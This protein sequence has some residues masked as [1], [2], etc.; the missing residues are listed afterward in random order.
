MAGDFNHNFD[1]P[2]KV[3]KWYNDMEKLQNTFDFKSIQGH[4]HSFKGNKKTNTKIDWIRGQNITI[5]KIK[6][7]DPGFINCDHKGIKARIEI[8]NKCCRKKL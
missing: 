8:P 6:E 2:N 3:K 4:T 7:I 5:S 1:D